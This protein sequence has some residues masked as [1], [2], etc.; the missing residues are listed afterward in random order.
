[1][2]TLPDRVRSSCAAVM[3]EAQ[4]VTIDH[5]VLEALAASYAQATPPPPAPTVST[6]PIDADQALVVMALDVI[7]FGSGYHDV[8]RKEPGLS[9]ARTM[10][11]RLRSY[12][13]VSGPLTS[14]R[15]RHITPADCSQIFGQEL[16][17]GAL[18]ELM[19]HFGIALNDLGVW[20]DDQ[21]GG[22]VLV[23]I[24][25]ADRSA[26]SLAESLLAM[27][28]F[29]DVEGVELPSG[30][31]E[32]A[33]YKRAQIT[34][35]DLERACGPGLFDDLDRL[36]AFADNLVPHVLRID[37]ALRLVPELVSTIDSGTRLVPGSRP[38]VELRA[39]GVVA[40][41]QLAELTGRRP[42]DLD[43]MLWERGSG[44]HY[45]SVRR[46]RARSVFY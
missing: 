13:E 3:T 44:A 23:A 22:S 6:T 18:E 7:N 43:M 11:A 37:G 32:V 19:V 10:A 12:V 17:G 35:A 4:F 5:E 8:V 45:K 40:V 29:R 9:G 15:L 31:L 26:A 42:M 33:F 16:D 28:Y 1:M 30:P 14:A 21:A 41:E 27:P 2:A 36:T 24:D 34:A 46:H 39:A 25:A 38:E 20:L